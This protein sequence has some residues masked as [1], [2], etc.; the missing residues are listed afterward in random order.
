ML[1]VASKNEQVTIGPKVLFVALQRICDICPLS[2]TKGF[3][4][5]DGVCDTLDRS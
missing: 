2:I 4:T 5:T 3:Q 1:H